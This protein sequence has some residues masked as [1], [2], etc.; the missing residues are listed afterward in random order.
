MASI[1]SPL[2]KLPDLMLMQY[3]NSPNFIKYLTCYAAEAQEVYSTFQ[4]CLTDRYYDVAVGA[5]LDVI[6]EIVGANRTLSGVVIAGNF[7]YLYNPESLGMGKISDPSLGG[8]L[9]SIEEDIIQDVELDDQLFRNWIEARILKCK[10]ACN[11]EDTISFFK[12]LLNRPELQVVITEPQEATAVVTLET[13]LSIHEAALVK[14]LAEHIK[15]SGI[16]YIVQDQKGVIPT[17]PVA[18]AR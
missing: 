1:T 18:F 2:Q 15:P 10:T 6:G 13:V 7:G 8:P 4:Q 11:I 16:T 12:L 17:L 3:R 9:R 14:S 5:Q